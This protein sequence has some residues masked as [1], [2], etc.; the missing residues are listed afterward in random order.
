MTCHHVPVHGRSA[1]PF[2]LA[3]GAL[4]YIALQGVKVFA[5]SDDA[6]GMLAAHRVAIVLAW[7]TIAVAWPRIP[8]TTR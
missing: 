3:L 6:T 5:V 4:V 1:R 2:E 7:I 8:Q